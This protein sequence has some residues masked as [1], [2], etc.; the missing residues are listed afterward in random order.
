MTPAPLLAEPRNS[1]L[2]FLKAGLGGSET[3]SSDRNLQVGECQVM[4]GTPP[5]PPIDV[6]CEGSL[7][8]TKQM[9]F[10]QF[11]TGDNFTDVFMRLNASG[12]LDLQYKGMVIFN[13]MALPGYT[14]LAGG[15]FVFGARTGGLNEYQWVANIAVATTPGLIPIAIGYAR[16]GND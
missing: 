7:V 14:A 10:A 3:A 15:V 13:G 9:P 5:A 16:V 4:H 2:G 1:A 11:E 8:G 12:T 6:L